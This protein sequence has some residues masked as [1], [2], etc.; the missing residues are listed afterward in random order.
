MSSEGYLID[1]TTRHQIYVQRHA[2][3]NLKEVAKFITLAIATAKDRVSAGLSVYGTKRYEKQIEVLQSDLRGIYAE[4]KGQAQ[5]DLSDFA[6]HESAFSAAML[7]A[8]V[9]VG[10]QVSTPSAQIVVSSA[11][12]RPMALEARKKGVQKISIS[13]ALDQFG[14][15]KAAEIISEI[16]IG[17]ALGETIQSIAKR[18]TGLEILQREQATAL[19]RTLTNHVA[20]TARMETLRA[21]GDILEGKRRVATLDGRTS[22]TCRALD[23]TVV[24]LD[25]PSPPFHWSCRTSEMPVIKA[26]YRREIPGSTRPSKGADGIEQVSSKTTYQEWLARQPAA[27]QKDVLGPSRYAL[28]SKGELTLDRFVDDNGRTLTLDQLK[29]KQP[30]A[31]E[32]AGLN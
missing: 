7:G 21:N 8:T 15:K 20:A 27:F 11:L 6:V 13:G 18:I 3:S 23:G 32:R 1:A 16:Q 5:A 26:Q 14:S 24:P 25:A 22:A 30:T 10:V 19:V 29:A 17:A 2:G 31:F 28:F 9:S 12:T 4:M